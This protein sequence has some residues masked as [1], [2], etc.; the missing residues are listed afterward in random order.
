MDFLNDIR[1]G[2]ELERAQMPDNGLNESPGWMNSLL[3]SISGANQQGVDNKRSAVNNAAANRYLEQS[4]RTRAELGITPDQRLTVGGVETAVRELK[5]GKVKANQERLRG[6]TTSDRDSGY[7]QQGLMGRQQIEASNNQFL[8]QQKSQDAR[9][10]HT[11]QQNRL[12]RG[13][14]RELSSNNTEM[15]MALG[16]MNADLADK[17]IDYDRETRRMDKRTAAIAQLMSGLGSLGG[18]FSL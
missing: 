15:Q 3:G 4:G 13:L 1:Y 18:A 14:E 10:A 11:D 9:Y 16:Q 7:A 2:V 6:Y 8:A 5:E 17:R 12:D